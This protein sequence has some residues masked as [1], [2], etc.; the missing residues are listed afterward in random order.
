MPCAVATDPN[1]FPSR[2]YRCN[3]RPPHHPSNRG[4]PSLCRNTDRGLELAL[5]WMRLAVTFLLFVWQQ[6]QKSNAGSEQQPVPW[7]V[8]VLC[9]WRA[10]GEGVRGAR[11]CN[12]WRQW[13]GPLR[14]WQRET[15]RVAHVKHMGELVRYMVELVDSISLALVKREHAPLGPAH[16]LST[17]YSS[18]WKSC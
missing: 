1:S 4:R 3:A 16:D 8:R 15:K 7:I 18:Y 5:G 9:D 11:L 17:R 14:T 6:C 12:G 2:A 10:V 13:L